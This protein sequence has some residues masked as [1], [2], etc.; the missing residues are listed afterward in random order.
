MAKTYKNLYDKIANI[1]NIKFAHKNA[2]KDKRYYTAVRYTDEHLDERAK[3]IYE[4]LREHSYEVSKYT[5]S[6]LHDTRKDRILYKLPYYPDRIIQWAIMLQVE[7]IFQEVFTDFTC[8]SLPNKGIH[9]ASNLLEK[10]LNNYPTETVYCL[11]MDIKKFYPTIDRAILKQLLRK[12]FRDKDLLIEL[13]KIIDSMEKTSLEHLPLDES[14]KA[15][16]SQKGKGLPV[17]SYLSQYFANFY[18]AYFDHWLKEEKGCKFV[19]RYMDDIVILSNSKEFLHNIRKESQ[20]YLEENLKLTIKSNYQVFPVDTRGVDF[21]GYRYFHG[22]KLI[23]KDIANKYKTQMRKTRKHVSEQGL[24]TQQQ[25]HSYNSYNGWIKRTSSRKL[26]HKY[27]APLRN[28]MQKYYQTH[29]TSNKNKIYKV[30]G[31]PIYRNYPLTQKRTHFLIHS[32]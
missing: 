18:L 12:K 10:Y 4:M 22:Y 14:T 27:S 31:P 30:G 25:W 29:I 16:Y 23:R 24:P 28:S 32:R 21:V 5:I 11:K 1:D 3:E 9:Y 2:R 15:L 6:I 7:D 19:I 20:R 17:G 8:A 13:D 26:Y